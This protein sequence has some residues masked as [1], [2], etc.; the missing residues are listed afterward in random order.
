MTLETFG[1]MV[2]LMRVTVADKTFYIATVSAQ[3][4][5]GNHAIQKL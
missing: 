3:N 4:A 2:A 5:E 1:T